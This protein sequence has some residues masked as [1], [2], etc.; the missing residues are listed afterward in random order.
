MDLNITLQQKHHD[1][2]TNKKRLLSIVILVYI[3][4]VKRLLSRKCGGEGG[5]AQT[6]QQAWLREEDDWQK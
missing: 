3:S 1:Q 4:A 5:R 6:E 2:L